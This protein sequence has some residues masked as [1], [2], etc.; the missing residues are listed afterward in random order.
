M[1]DMWFVICGHDWLSIIY[2]CAQYCGLAN[3]YMN[4]IQVLGIDLVQK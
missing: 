4:H 1:L 2:L 3:V